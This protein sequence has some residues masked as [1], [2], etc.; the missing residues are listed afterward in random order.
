MADP[1]LVQAFLHKVVLSPSL[2]R[3]IDASHLTELVSLY[4]LAGV[5]LDCSKHPWPQAKFVA[6]LQVLQRT[7][8]WCVRNQLV[9]Q[10]VRH[11]HCI[12]VNFHRPVLLFIQTLRDNSMPN[13]EKGLCVEAG[14]S[15]QVGKSSPAFHIVRKLQNQGGHDRCSVLEG[16]YLDHSAF[17]EESV[18]LTSEDAGLLCHVAP[19]NSRLVSAH[20]YHIEAEKGWAPGGCGR[21]SCGRYRP[22][23]GRLRRG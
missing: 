12:R 16:P 7:S 11:E 22:G 19:H 15:G 21:Q 23:C 10:P 3:E 6:I 13:S 5:D 9:G 17:S 14:C 20:R 1:K 4:G 2:P 8:R 18:G